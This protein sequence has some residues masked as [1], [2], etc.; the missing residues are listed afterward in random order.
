MKSVADI[1]SLWGRTID[2]AEAV[3]VEY[4]TAHQWIRRNR[5]PPEH[6]LALVK[7]AKLRGFP[8]TEA[9]LAEMTVAQKRR[10]IAER[11]KSRRRQ[12][13]ARERQ[14]VSA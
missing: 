10:V 1:I 12:R 5:V 11:E 9:L 3:G 14:A 4:M 7:A 13:S 2:F 6:W 8:I